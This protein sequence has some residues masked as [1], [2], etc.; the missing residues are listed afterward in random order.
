[1]GGKEVTTGIENTR[2]LPVM[3]TVV[4]EDELRH[5]HHHVY[6]LEELGRRLQT[7]EASVQATQVWNQVS[8]T[9]IVM[10]VTVSP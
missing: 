5:A 9:I 10:F 4:V 3:S 7:Q 8:I 2:T 1:M 6:P